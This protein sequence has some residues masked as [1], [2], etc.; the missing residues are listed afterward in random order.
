MAAEFN[1]NTQNIQTTVAKWLESKQKLDEYTKKTEKYRKLIELYMIE[2]G[3]KE[4]YHTSHGGIGNATHKVTLST[5]SRETLGK[6]DVPSD[7]WEKYC[8]A[9]RF[10]TLR[11]KELKDADSQ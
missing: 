9:T 4:L 11:V 5:C 8:K 7:L 6:R 10:R 3:A 2:N 1:S